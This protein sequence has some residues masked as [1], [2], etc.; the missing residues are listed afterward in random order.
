MT[1][2]A[3]CDC[4]LTLIKRHSATVDWYWSHDSLRTSIDTLQTT[5]SDRRLSVSMEVSPTVYR[6]RS[7]MFTCVM[8]LVYLVWAFV[9]RYMGYH[10]YPVTVS[11][12]VRNP[13]FVQLLYRH[14]WRRYFWS[15]QRSCWKKMHFSSNLCR[16]A[17]MRTETGR[18]TTWTWLHTWKL[19]PS[20]VYMQRA[21]AHKQF[22]PAEMNPNAQK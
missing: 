19:I 11:P 8:G 9:L 6:L 3:V 13:P 1:V 22:L 21:T 15:V 5:V 4:L 12:F 18:W 20:C 2:D 7:N 17:F 16:A 10:G 14:W